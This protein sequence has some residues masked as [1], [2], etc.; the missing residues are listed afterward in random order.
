MSGYHTSVNLLNRYAAVL[1]SAVSVPG[2]DYISVLSGVDAHASR[3]RGGIAPI[4]PVPL[5]TY[6]CIDYCM[7]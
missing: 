7:R 2:Y 6:C 5:V 1:G 4:R 3:V